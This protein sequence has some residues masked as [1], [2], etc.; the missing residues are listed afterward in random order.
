MPSLPARESVPRSPPPRSRERGPT[1]PAQGLFSA[2][3]PA[4]SSVATRPAGWPAFGSVED[5]LLA[6]GRSS[7]D[8]RDDGDGA[9]DD[10]QHAQ[11]AG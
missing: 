7:V 1:V 9:A 6:G 5:P 10:G 11:D 8:S 4:T 2:A 3:Q